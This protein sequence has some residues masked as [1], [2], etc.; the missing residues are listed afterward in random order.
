MRL[1]AAPCFQAKGKTGHN[2]LKRKKGTDLNQKYQSTSHVVKV[3]VFCEMSASIITKDGC[4]HH[5]TMLNIFL[6]GRYGRKNL[7]RA[8]G[9]SKWT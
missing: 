9:G 1:H 4:V 5:V 7:E 8:G 6:T 3:N 2:E